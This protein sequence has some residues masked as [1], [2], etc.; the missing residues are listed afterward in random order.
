MAYGGCC[1]LQADGFSARI[2]LI[3]LL[4][5]ARYAYLLFS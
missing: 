3:F 5:S 4:I 2:I 1:R